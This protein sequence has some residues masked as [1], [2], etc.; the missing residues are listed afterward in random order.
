MT[1]SRMDSATP[2]DWAN[3]S[4]AARVRN[5]SFPDKILQMLKELESQEDGFAIN[6]LQHGLQTATRAYHDGASEELIVSALCHDIGKV[7]LLKGHPEI[8]AAILKPFVSSD[9]YNV[10][11]THQDFQ[12][13]YYA[14]ITN[15][16]PDSRSK[17][18]HEPWYDLACKFTDSWDQKSFDPNYETLPLRFFEPMIR[19]IFSPENNRLF[20]SVSPVSDDSQ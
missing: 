20:T 17:H 16:D 3:V 5:S 18:A 4:Q 9:V 6:Q 19:K 14:H 8:S 7:V 1:I 13:K 15:M 2:E 12:V 10:I 11:R